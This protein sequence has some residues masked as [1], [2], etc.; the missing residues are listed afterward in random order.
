MVTLDWRLWISDWHTLRAVTC[1]HQS[2]FL[3]FAEFERAICSILHSAII[4]LRSLL[5]NSASV[6]NRCSSLMS[7]ILCGCPELTRASKRGDKI[8]AKIPYFSPKLYLFCNT[9]RST[10]QCFWQ[11]I[12]IRIRILHKIDFQISVPILELLLPFNCCIHIICFFK[13]NKS[14]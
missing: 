10:T 6:R 8:V 14:V 12:K 11:I 3:F 7:G 5:Q 2:S 4:F 13:I 1:R 9:S